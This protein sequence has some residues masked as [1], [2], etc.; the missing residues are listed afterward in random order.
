MGGEG[1]AVLV[2]GRAGGVVPVGIGRGLA[3]GFRVPVSSKGGPGGGVP[4]TAIGRGGWITGRKTALGRGGRIAEV[5]VLRPKDLRGSGIQLPPGSPGR[6]FREID[7]GRPAGKCRL[8]DEVCRVQRGWQCP[9]TGPIAEN[10]HPKH[11]DELVGRRIAVVIARI[12]LKLAYRWT[13]HGRHNVRQTSIAQLGGIEVHPQAETV[14]RL[15]ERIRRVVHVDSDR[16]ARVD[17][18]TERIGSNDLV[19]GQRLWICKQRIKVGLYLARI[20]A[21][22]VRIHRTGNQIFPFQSGKVPHDDHAVGQRVRHSV[23]VHIE[24]G[25]RCVVEALRRFLCEAGQA[26]HDQRPQWQVG[27]RAGVGQRLE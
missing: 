4:G 9:R 15:V 3:V 21:H 5:L 26:P 18:L 27:A 11:Q 1:H 2:V 13:A 24:R 20:G 12:V 14:E 8:C 25:Q 6:A 10:I 7:V 17:T 22:S 19:I 16:I 23:V